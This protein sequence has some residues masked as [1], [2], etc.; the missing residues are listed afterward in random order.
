MLSFQ[1]PRMVFRLSPA[2]CLGVLNRRHAF[3]CGWDHCGFCSLVHAQSQP[4]RQFPHTCIDYDQGPPVDCISAAAP[5][6]PC[7]TRLGRVSFLL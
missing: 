3:T 4:Q 2:R 5:Q 7:W 6:T 1:S